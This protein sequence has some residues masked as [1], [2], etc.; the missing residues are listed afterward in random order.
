M[1]SIGVGVK[2][3]KKKIRMVLEFGLQN[4]W[5]GLDISPH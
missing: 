5:Y 2:N 1:A 4:Y 3:S